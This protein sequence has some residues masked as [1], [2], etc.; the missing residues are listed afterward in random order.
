LYI[1]MGNGQEAGNWYVKYEE[2]GGVR[3]EWLINQI[4]ELNK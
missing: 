1:D 3:N 2:N 4:K